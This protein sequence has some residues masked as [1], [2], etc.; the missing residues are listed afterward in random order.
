MNG[1][2]TILSMTMKMKKKVNL[3]LKVK[4]YRVLITRLKSFGMDYFG[5]ELYRVFGFS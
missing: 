3:D 5:V 4:S 1:N 2:G